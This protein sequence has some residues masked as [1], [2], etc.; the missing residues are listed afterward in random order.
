MLKPACARRPDG[1]RARPGA[2]R[3]VPEAGKAIGG[4]RAVTSA[5]AGTPGADPGSTGSARSGAETG[6]RRRRYSGLDR[7]GGTG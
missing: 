3:R 4:P 7:S 2:P 5:P 1:R 6:T